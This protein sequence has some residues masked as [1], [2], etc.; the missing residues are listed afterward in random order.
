MRITDLG[1]GQDALRWLVPFLSRVGGRF[2]QRPCPAHAGRGAITRGTGCQRKAFQRDDY[3]F[4]DPEK[5]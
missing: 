3:S 4:V 1:R 5:R 2:D